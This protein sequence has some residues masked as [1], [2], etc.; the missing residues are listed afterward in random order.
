MVT[1]IECHQFPAVSGVAMTQ[2]PA[3]W[4]GFAVVFLGF[5]A[6]YAAL[7]SPDFM[8]VDGGVR[9]FGVYHRQEIFF[10]GNNHM[11]YPVN[12]REWDQL[13]RSIVG[14]CQDPLEFARRTQLM[15]GLAT[16]TSVAVLFM[17]MHV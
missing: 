13:V 8:A 10:H 1:S 15:N 12:V 16:A 5:F 14:P 9:C 7:R 11:L 17:L 4:I 3:R 2:P 6:I